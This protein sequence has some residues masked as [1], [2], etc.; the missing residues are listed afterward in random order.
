[1]VK[2][3]FSLVIVCVL[4]AS[5]LGIT[6]FATA[7]G[8][9][10]GAPRMPKG[11]QNL[12]DLS[13]LKGDTG[14]FDYMKDSLVCKGVDGDKSAVVYFNVK[15]NV[16]PLTEEYVIS[17]WARLP[18][19]SPDWT[20]FAVH[21]NDNGTDVIKWSFAPNVVYLY[22]NAQPHAEITNIKP[23]TG[24]WFKV[25][26]HSR[27]SDDGRAIRNV[28]I[29]NQQLKN[30]WA[31]NTDM[32]MD[33]TNPV[34]RIEA[35]NIPFELSSFRMYR[36]DKSATEFE[37]VTKPVEF[38]KPSESSSVSKSP[39][40]M[41]ESKPDSSRPDSSSEESA[42]SEPSEAKEES[43]S[44]GTSS[45]V[46]VVGQSE[47]VSPWVWVSIIIVL[48]LLGGGLAIFFVLK[49]GNA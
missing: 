38:E 46:G 39:S 26:I 11:A 43:S 1:M 8:P 33:G 15:G 47:G 14:D 31:N 28:Y 29:N 6:A 4:L 22:L 36:V 7:V 16:N 21:T 19:D 35:F 2:R 20:G 40:S 42:P 23:P 37:A 41:I 13:S 45:A 18:K 9:S 17:F 24:Q 30:N 34:F 5:L 48:V 12:I 3:L 44:A 27:P 25:D 49:K 32:I 10:V